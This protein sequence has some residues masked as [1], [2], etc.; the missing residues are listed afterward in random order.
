MKA[1]VEIV[2]I[3]P[4]QAE[5]L[6]S[7]QVKEQ[8][9]L[10]NNHVKNLAQ[11][12][13]DGNFRLSADA[14]VV[15]KGALANGQHRL[16]AVIE[17]GTTQQFLM[18]DTDDDELYKVL[19][20]GLKRSVGDAAHINNS[21]MVCASASLALGYLNSTLTQFSYL[22]K[23]Q[24]SEMIEFVQKHDEQLQ[25][26]HR[27]M[28]SLTGHHQNLAPRTV[29]AAFVVIS[30]MAGHSD[31]GVDFMSHVYA[32]DVSGTACHDLRERFI[33]MRM[34]KAKYPSQYY[35]ALMIKAFNSYTQ[36]TRPAQ[37][38]MQD[39]ESYPKIAKPSKT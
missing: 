30:R 21:T 7:S 13:K 39:S 18:M 28:G 15:I 31:R 32:G 10:R 12:M 34:E 1:T 16:W 25:E 5:E 3:T 9:H 6:L 2:K 19:D 11:D 22:K 38:R 20:C 4:K 36:G 26:A 37:L 33:R 23:N 35:L 27:L 29:G 8:R 14:L 24:R 17:S